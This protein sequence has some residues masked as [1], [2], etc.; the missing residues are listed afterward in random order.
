ME[1]GYGDDEILIAGYRI[2]GAGFAGS[3]I[4]RF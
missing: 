1:A 4:Y 3:G 2:A